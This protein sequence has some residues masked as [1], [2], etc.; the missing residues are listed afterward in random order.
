MRR[1]GVWVA[2]AICILYA[3]QALDPSVLPQGLQ[4]FGLSAV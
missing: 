3:V 1:V 4:Y 2:G